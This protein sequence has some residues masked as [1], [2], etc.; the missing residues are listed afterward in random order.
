[1]SITIL[2]T[3]LY[4]KISF[5][6]SR[7]SKKQDTINPY[8]ILG[9]DRSA[10]D[11]EIKKAYKTLAMKFHPD[12][13]QTVD[14]TVL[15]Q[16][17]STAYD[18]LTTSNLK[19]NYEENADDD[20]TPLKNVAG[21]LGIGK[22]LSEDFKK[23]LDKWMK[24]YPIVP[25]VD[26]ISQEIGSIFEEFVNPLLFYPLVA[27]ASPA[28]YKCPACNKDFSTKKIH[29]D[30]FIE[31]YTNLIKNSATKSITEHMQELIGKNIPQKVIY[32]PINELLDWL[33]AQIKKIKLVTNNFVSAIGDPVPEFFKEIVGN[34]FDKLLAPVL[35]ANR[36]DLNLLIDNS[37]TRPIKKAIKDRI[38][39]PFGIFKSDNEK[40]IK[41]GS[42]DIIPGISDE[43]PAV[44]KI[45]IA[46][47]PDLVPSDQR[48][49]CRKCKTRFGIFTW[50]N[51]CRSCGEIF[52]AAC[53]KKSPIRKF[54]FMFDVRVCINCYNIQQHNEPLTWINHAMENMDNEMHSSK[55]LLISMLYGINTKTY[56]NV[57]EKAGD[58]FLAHYKYCLAI[59]SYQYAKINIKKWVSLFEML[60]YNQKYEL[61]LGLMEFIGDHFR[62]Q[63]GAW[64]EYGN[65]YL[66]KC[67]D[68]VA[69]SQVERMERTDASA[70]GIIVLLSLFCYRKANQ[71]L[72]EMC[73]IALTIHENKNYALR[74]LYLV[75][76]LK[77]YSTGKQLTAI[78]KIFFNAKV[79][80]VAMY[81]YNKGGYKQNK[82]VSRVHKLCLANKFTTAIETWKNV[83]VTHKID[84]I[85]N[86]YYY[87]KYIHL[88]LTNSLSVDDLLSELVNFIKQ[89]NITEANVCV[90]FVTLSLGTTSYYQM[91]DSY[92]VKKDFT[93]AFI[94]YRLSELL[95]SNNSGWVDLGHKLIGTSDI[96]Q[97]FQCFAYG[98]VVWKE[99]ADEFFAKKRFTSALNCY[100]LSTDVTIGQHIFDSACKLLS[101][102]NIPKALI[103]FSCLLGDN[104]FVIEIV[105]ELGKYIIDKPEYA[106][107][108]KNLIIAALKIQPDVF[109]QQL[110]FVHDYLGKLFELNSAINEIIGCL[111]IVAEY[112]TSTYARNKINALVKI[113]DA[114]ETSLFTTALTQASYASNSKAIVLMVND[115]DE[116]KFNAVKAFYLEQVKG[117]IL[118]LPEHYRCVMY[119]LSAAMNIYQGSYIAA[120][121]DLQSSLVCFPVNTN[122]EAVSILLQNDK[123]QVEIYKHFMGDLVKFNGSVP[124]KIDIPTEDQYQQLLKGSKLLTM[125][126]K[127]E[128]AV[129]RIDDPVEAGLLYLDLCMAVSDASGLAGCFIMSAM[130]FLKAQEQTTNPEKIYAYRNA[131]FYMCSNA[132][133]I[134]HRNLTPTMQIYIYKLVISLLINCN[135]VLA[136]SEKQNPQKKYFNSSPCRQVA[137]RTHGAFRAMEEIYAQS[138]PSHQPR[139]INESHSAILKSIVKNIVT[140][141]KISPI[142]NLPTSLS[143]DTIYLDLASRSYTEPYLR[144]ISKSGSSLCPK[145]IADYYL[146]EGAWKHWFA[147]ENTN[148]SE[149]RT[150]SM[151]SLLESRGWDTKHVE[152]LMDWQLFPRTK[153]GW[154]DIKKSSLNFCIDS[155]TNVHG[156]SIS[157]VT[158]EI[159]F[160]LEPSK[161][162]T[163]GLF[164]YD[165]VNA[166][167]V[168]GIQGAFFTLDQPDVNLQS[169]PFQE[170]KYHPKVLSG[171]DY[172]ATL[173]Q[174][175]YLLKMFSMGVDVNSKAPF[176][177]RPAEE[178][179]INKLPYHLRDV[180]KPIHKR[181]NPAE[182]GTA[183]RFWI[184]AGEVLY[185]ISETE[186]T[187]T[188]ELSDVKMKVKKHLLKYDENGKLVDDES[189]IELDDSAEA[190]FAADFTKYY[191]EIGKSFPELLRLKELLK[192]GAVYTILVNIYNNTQKL[193]NTIN[194]DTSLVE[195]DL[196]S[197]RSQIKEYP[198]Y[199]ES[200]VYSAYNDILRQ[201]GLYSDTNVAPNEITRTKDNIRS[202][203]QEA[204]VK[205]L[206]QVTDILA[207]N[208]HTSAYG[209]KSNVELWLKY[210]GSYTNTLSGVLAASVKHYLISE[211]R[212]IVTGIQAMNV[213]TNADKFVSLGNGGECPWV[214]ATYCFNEDG[215]RR[216]KVYGGVNLGLNMRQGAVG[217]NTYNIY[218]ANTLNR[219]ANPADRGH[220]FP[221]TFDSHVIQN[222]SMTSPASRDGRPYNLY[223]MPGGLGG[224]QGTYT[225]GVRPVQ[226]AAGNTINLITHRC[227]YGNK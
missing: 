52:C 102:N 140:L 205:I 59:Q 72:E 101:T 97:A 21:Y 100:L 31:S 218:S 225:V 1:M 120:L 163:K 227:F 22:T 51:N 96:S 186:T 65:S 89:K 6:A 85:P 151:N 92:I 74:D 37:N 135:L 80:D 161:D 173:L 215:Q 206:D 193:I 222:G 19:A 153:D 201:N 133:E 212:K 156:L 26:N 119:L 11:D 39:S 221:M 41:N 152:M 67:T 130:Q 3:S 60:V 217:G 115:L 188:C 9:I 86:R 149:A 93:K 107:P 27:K 77:N 220:R 94:C 172:L 128:R 99:L 82:W 62:L 5:M 179:L 73:K 2:I 154:L 46:A 8:N 145:Y 121:S 180:L 40:R 34:G 47:P 182:H 13:N 167:L 56:C 197:I 29:D 90:L 17:I 4:S 117:D 195:K 36:Y 106:V 174:T 54:G 171:T 223:S 178:N 142:I 184:E 158:G 43:F 224:S 181:K 214:P 122:P 53:L 124:I 147:N 79:Y 177:F 68:L 191:D 170:M 105:K 146:L 189:D 98:Q 210:G 61:A 78:A 116:I 30:K 226:T 75:Y 20:D 190:Q 91:T 194:I 219:M 57:M 14:T 55:M 81:F 111:H 16:Q 192:L 187:I 76:L 83:M 200:N 109:N 169:H 176:E 126:K 175:D 166:V 134:A 198:V 70:C 118:A 28:K 87:A 32:Q 136:E 95:A 211:K 129:N 162:Q 164:T 7:K 103:Y 209:I 185:Q 18:I 139:I 202:Q 50:K 159:S 84:T 10:T 49:N 204:D 137:G 132:Y 58:Y 213:N 144:D 25:L 143:C 207:K 112:D 45:N 15:F 104:K 108:F 157:K 42:F 71:S 12:K 216:S 138:Y 155:F 199:T 196:R 113:L 150:R 64:I 183:H 35:S 114:K 148:F 123:L 131:I 168:L 23:K 127:F 48:T 66:N 63:P 38:S 208:Y 69:K 110:V 203:L 160:F 165:D 141:A 33:P 88:Y 24:E 44:S 125:I